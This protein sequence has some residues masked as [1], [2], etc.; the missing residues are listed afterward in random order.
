MGENELCISGVKYECQTRGNGCYL[1]GGKSVASVQGSGAW[2]FFINN[3]N[4]RSNDV[5]TAITWYHPDGNTCSEQQYSLKQALLC[6]YHE[7]NG[8]F[9]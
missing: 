6:Q 5:F 8:S 9:L 1:L 2:Q 4:M 7:W 3:K